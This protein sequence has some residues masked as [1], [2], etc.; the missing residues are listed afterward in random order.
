MFKQNLALRGLQSKIG[1]ALSAI[2]LSP[3]SWTLLSV[4]MAFV[5]GMVIAVSG[6][7]LAGIILFALSALSD[8]FDG[9]VARARNQVS[10]YGGFLDG[11]ADRFV[12]AAFLF[13]FMFFPLPDIFIQ[14]KIW[15]AGV[16]FLGTCMPS[17]IRAYAHHKEVLTSEQAHAVGGICERSERMLILIVGLAA[18]MLFSMEYFVYA[19]ILVCALSAITILQRLAAVKLK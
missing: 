2:P 8:A 4:L 13:S 5:G 12:E 7:L 9:A 14:A 18:G 3:N 11:V 6:N 17:F 15:L 19:L 1:K 10:K 16:V